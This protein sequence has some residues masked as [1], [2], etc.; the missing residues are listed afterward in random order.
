VQTPQRLELHQLA[1][2]ETRRF[3]IVCLE[4]RQACPRVRDTE[5]TAWRVDPADRLDQIGQCSSRQRTIKE[6][7]VHPPGIDLLEDM[8]FLT[9][10]LVIQIY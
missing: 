8:G 3:K 5:L 9:L 4:R 10:E 2:I 1:F 6:L 7:A